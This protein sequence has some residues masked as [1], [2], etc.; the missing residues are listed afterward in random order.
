M[1]Q[2]SKLLDTLSE[3]FDKQ[4]YRYTT[5]DFVYR[6]LL[7]LE[8]LSDEEKDDV[9]KNDLIYKFLLP[10]LEERSFYDNDELPYKVTFDIDTEG[11]IFKNYIDGVVRVAKTHNLTMESHRRVI[12]MLKY[13][14]V[15]ENIFSQNSFIILYKAY[16]ELDFYNILLNETKKFY[17]YIDRTSSQDSQEYDKRD[18]AN[19]F[20]SSMYFVEAAIIMW[21]E[22]VADSLCYELFMNMTCTV[23]ILNRIMNDG[24]VSEVVS[25]CYKMLNED[26]KYM[27]MK[28]LVEC[29]NSLKMDKLRRIIGIVDSNFSLR[30]T[31]NLEYH[32]SAYGDKRIKKLMFDSFM[33]DFETEDED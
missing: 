11:K 30:T 21:G 3:I 9:I 29:W 1:K 5:S 18:L 4:H 13:G 16:P 33:K 27:C 26:A 2:T 20:S 7:I 19:L 32:I 14:G 23:K 24:A 22:E 28:N 15:K 25:R 8:T 31:Y 10:R 6:F 12:R 17:K